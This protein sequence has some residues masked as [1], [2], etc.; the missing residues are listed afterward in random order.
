MT[1]TSRLEKSL[2]NSKMEKMNANVGNQT[3]QIR[4]CI[5]N[6]IH[7]NQI[8]PE[9]Q[10][11]RNQYLV[12]QQ[13]K[14]NDHC[15]FTQ[16]PKNTTYLHPTKK[17]STDVVGFSSII[18]QRERRRKEQ[19][20]RMIV[21]GEKGVGKTTFLQSLLYDSIMEVTKHKDYTRYKAKLDNL[22][23]IATEFKGILWKL[24]INRC[25]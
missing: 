19:T 24:T 21:M 13:T 12:S 14:E 9:N 25:I 23:V 10:V 6:N 17:E 8:S 4:D 20:L 5:P 11:R 3:R 16:V 15:S 18:A 2:E 1:S 22:T 7:N